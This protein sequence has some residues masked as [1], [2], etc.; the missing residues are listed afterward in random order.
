MQNAMQGAPRKT[1]VLTRARIQRRGNS[2]SREA[3]QAAPGNTVRRS[4]LDPAARAERRR[5]VLHHGI[6]LVCL[7]CV[8]LLYVWL[9]LQVLNQGYALSASTK[10]QQRLEQ[11]QRELKLEQATLTS[12]ERI[13]AM[14]RRRL[15]LRAPEKG[16][17]IVLP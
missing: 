9:R 11:E 7:A 2:A 6:A 10:L 16:Q 4:R 12:P 3:R 5:R 13:E 15:G 1:E 17:V 8:V 14:A